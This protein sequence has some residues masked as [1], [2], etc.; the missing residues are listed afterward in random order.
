[1]VARARP[2]SGFTLP[3]LLVTLTV[4][5]VLGSVA[6]PS[7]KELIVKQR[8][9]GASSELYASLLRTRSEAIKLNRD[10]TVEAV[11][12]SWTNGWKVVNPVD[13]STLEL[14]GALTSAA[15]TGSA[16]S[17]VYMGNGRV[18]ASAAPS[19]LFIGSGISEQSC[20]QIDLSGR[21]YQKRAAC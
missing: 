15:I 9:R 5:L 18:R 13:S 3:E 2:H 1:M 21:P 17:V 4:V 6:A 8:V 20:I 11:S 7:M 14:H 12:G 10:V 19:F 16:S